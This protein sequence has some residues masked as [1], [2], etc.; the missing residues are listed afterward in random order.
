M[1][2]LNSVEPSTSILAFPT[3]IWDII[4][5][6]VE[7]SGLFKL[8]YAG[9]RTLSAKLLQVSNVNAHWMS[10]RP[11]DWTQCLPFISQFSKLKS[12]TIGAQRPSQLPKS[13]LVPE[14]LPSSMVSLTL[15]FAGALDLL[16]GKTR[17]QSLAS[18]EYL[19]VAS[20]ACVENLSTGPRGGYI[21]LSQFPR[22]LRHLILGYLAPYKMGNYFTLR[23]EG[24]PEGLITFECPIPIR[25]T[26]KIV[27]GSPDHP[28]SLTYLEFYAEPDCFIEIAHCADTL[29]TLR[30]VVGTLLYRNE[31]I[32]RLSSREGIPLRAIFP[33][34]TTLRLSWSS[35]TLPWHIFETLPLSLTGIGSQFSFST[36]SDMELCERL[37]QAYLSSTDPNRPGAPAMIQH[38]HLSDGT[39]AS[40]QSPDVNSWM[41]FFPSL[42]SLT[43]PKMGISAIDELPKEVVEMKAGN[44]STDP[45][46]LP[47]SLMRLFC[48]SLVLEDSKALVLDSSPENLDLSLQTHFKFSSLVEL[49]IARSFLTTRIISLLPSTLE[50]LNC[51]IQSHDVL[52][53]LTHRANVEHLLPLL[54]SLI[55]Q[56]HFHS[57]NTYGSSTFISINTIPRTIDTLKLNTIMDFTDPQSEC[58]LR[59]HPSLTDFTVNYAENFTK[60]MPQLPPQLVNFAVMLRRPVDLNASEDVQLLSNMPRS[61]ESVRFER[62]NVKTSAWFTPFT[63]SSLASLR[64]EARRLPSVHLGLHL[65]RA[66]PSSIIPDSMLWILSESFVMSC[67]PRNVISFS[68]AQPSFDLTQHPSILQC[69]LE[70]FLNRPAWGLWRSISTF[71]LPLVSLCLPSHYRRLVPKDSHFGLRCKYLPPNI[72]HFDPGDYQ[73]SRLRNSY[74]IE[75]YANVPSRSSLENIQIRFVWRMLLH[76]LNILVWSSLGLSGIMNPNR[77]ISWLPWAITL[78]SALAIPT[79]CFTY[80]FLLRSSI[81]MFG[82]AIREHWK[83]APLA[84]FIMITVNAAGIIGLGLSASRWS[85]SSRFASLLLAL[86]GEI[87]FTFAVSEC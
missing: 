48:D 29:R 62:E 52:E 54:T 67:I 42:R 15:L 55:L 51:S 65:L 84:L 8:I 14:M 12:L 69:I 33:R 13:P 38:L 26:K 63:R 61:L 1:A 17:F 82:F 64:S 37:N 50:K 60:I 10:L 21:D 5:P 23:P 11:C 66:L 83:L 58:S 6:N 25:R 77:Y 75:R 7:D 76:S 43:F 36:N 47:R 81:P 22:N 56:N 34:L 30:V 86:I 9:N 16:V 31:P 27:W 46:R 39:L 68:A 4:L 70:F 40:A 3:E 78:G 85:F 44:I 19:R 79:Q 18:L 71:R 35:E 57:S 45:Q 80:R 32:Q 2:S 28:P 74:L 87:L 72:S 24:L 49:H 41:R 20:G 53:A 73:F 59:H